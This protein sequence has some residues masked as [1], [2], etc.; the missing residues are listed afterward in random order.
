MVFIVLVIFYFQDMRC[1]YVVLVMATYW[2]SEV[3]PLAV[4]A[5]LPLVLYPTFGVM[6]SSLVAQSYLKVPSK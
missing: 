2:I 4:T 1:L 5:L 3:L 6:T